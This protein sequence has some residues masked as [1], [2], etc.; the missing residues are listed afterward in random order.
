[1]NKSIYK[2]LNV[3]YLKCYGQRREQ[4]H[5]RERINKQNYRKYQAHALYSACKIRI[6]PKCSVSRLVSKDNKGGAKEIKLI[7]AFGDAN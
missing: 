5:F 1:M 4:A 3:L 2:I 6:P 7:F